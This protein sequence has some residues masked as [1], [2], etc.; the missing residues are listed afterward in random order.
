MSY[1]VAFS[2][3]FTQR[4]AAVDSREAAVADDDN[5]NCRSSAT[6]VRRGTTKLGLM[7]YNLISRTSLL[8]VATAL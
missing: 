7:I 6:A 2:Q 8:D 3:S 1:W 5:N 4:R